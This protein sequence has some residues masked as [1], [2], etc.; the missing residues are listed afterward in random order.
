MS[1]RVAPLPV[2]MGLE[3]GATVVVSEDGDVGE[4]VRCGAEFDVGVEA[5]FDRGATVFGVAEGVGEA[6][7]GGFV[8]EQRVAGG[9]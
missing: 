2:R 1:R 5:E 4:Q 7:A 6:V 9:V 3:G 8:A